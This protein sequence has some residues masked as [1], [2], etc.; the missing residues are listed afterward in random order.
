MPSIEKG[1]SESDYVKRCIPFVINKEGLSPEAAAAKCHGMYKQH[2][3]KGTQYDYFEPPESGNAPKEVKGILKSAYSNCRSRHKQDFP[4]DTEE[5]NKTRCS[6]ISWGAVQNAGWHKDEKGIWK[7][8]INHEFIIPITY[9][10]NFTSEEI[11]KATGKEMPSSFCY[12]YET[13]IDGKKKKFTAM[14]AVAIIGDR[15]MHG[16]FV[17]S[18]KIIESLNAWNGTIHDINHMGTNYPDPKP[19]YSRQNIE[20]VVGYNNFPEYDEKTKSLILTV[21]ISHDSPKYNVWQ[22][23]ID[24]C[25]AS[26]TIPNVS[27]AIDGAMKFERAGNLPITEKEYMDQGYNKND[28]VPYVDFIKPRGLT[29]AIRGVCDDKKGC[30]LGIRFEENESNCDCSSSGA[31][32]NN[33]DNKD[34]EWKKYLERRINEMKGEK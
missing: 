16:A 8:S 10:K 2:K 34:I 18:I 23:Y 24:I 33:N 5:E 11:L 27:A 9:L 31:C 7:K 15:F 3:E 28:F 12:E 22:S 20:Y 29:T 19:P 21:N 4:N 30:G 14:K 1:E 26:G 32:E 13:I 17:P 6:K 25:K